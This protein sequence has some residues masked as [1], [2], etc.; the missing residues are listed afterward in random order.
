MDVVSAFDSHDQAT[1]GTASVVASSDAAGNTGDVGDASTSKV[2]AQPKPEA[3]VGDESKGAEGAVVVAVQESARSKA[4]AEQTLDDHWWVGLRWVG[5][6]WAPIVAAFSSTG[7]FMWAH[8]E[9]GGSHRVATTW[10]EE[11]IQQCVYTRGLCLLKLPVRCWSLLVLLVLLLVLHSSAPPLPCLVH[12][13]PTDYYAHG[14]LPAQTQRGVMIVGMGNGDVPAQFFPDSVLRYARKVH[15]RIPACGEAVA[16]ASRVSV[17]RDFACALRCTCA[18][19]M[20]I[21]ACACL[22]ALSAGPWRLHHQCVANVRS[23][24]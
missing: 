18:Q 5:L 9:H 16:I 6:G 17:R 19:W 7:V 2:T 23:D 13:S 20:F 15:A 3:S 1:T 14:M 4:S 22:V 11:E 24:G 12:G 10:E 21:P 8:F